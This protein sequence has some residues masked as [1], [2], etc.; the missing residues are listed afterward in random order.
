MFASGSISGRPRRQAT[1]R[2]LLTGE[3]YRAAKATA[4][5]RKQREL[6]KKIRIQMP[7]MVPAQDLAR[8]TPRPRAC[9]GGTEG[10]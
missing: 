3:V 1:W 10:C 9:A 7:S 4:V 6:R 5:A 2:M 8:V